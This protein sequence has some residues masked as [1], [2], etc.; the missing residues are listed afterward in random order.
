[1]TRIA[2]FLALGL[3]LAGCSTERQTTT[4]RTATEQLLISAAA[5][6][7]AAALAGQVPTGRKAFV[8]ATNFEAV[9]G[10]YAIGSI[11]AAILARGTPLVADRKDADIVVEIRS[12]ALGIDNADTLVGSPELNVPI[13]LTTALSIPKV[14]FFEKERQLGIAKFAA[15]ILDA[16]TGESAAATQPE[17]GYAHKTKYTVAIAFSWKTDDITPENA[18]GIAGQ[19]ILLERQDDNAE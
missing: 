19:E 14:A 6:R 13:P 2:Y 3:V 9:D 8:D 10:K 16:K 11:R 15:A 4:S 18:S 17:F 1:M 5:D 12:G 7:A